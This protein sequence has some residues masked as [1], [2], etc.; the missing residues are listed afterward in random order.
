MV[1]GYC[2][3]HAEVCNPLTKEGVKDSGGFVSTTDTVIGQREKRP[4]H[5]YRYLAVKMIGVPVV[6]QSLVAD[7]AS[8]A[9]R[10]DTVPVQSLLSSVHSLF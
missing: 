8:Y 5:M 7:H 4:I 10:C 9:C 2:R 1:F 6:M 3:R